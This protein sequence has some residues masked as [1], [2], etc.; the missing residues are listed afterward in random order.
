MLWNRDFLAI[1]WLRL[2]AAI[3]GSRVQSLVRELNSR[4]PCGTAKKKKR[5]FK[6]KLNLILKIII[7]NIIF[8]QFKMIIL[9]R[10]E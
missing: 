1:H 8:S 3:A 5:K 4:M 9:G 6:T 10:V 7:W 2:C